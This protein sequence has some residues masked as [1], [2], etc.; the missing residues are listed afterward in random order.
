[1]NFRVGADSGFRRHGVGLAG[2]LDVSGIRV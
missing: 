1:M 2:L